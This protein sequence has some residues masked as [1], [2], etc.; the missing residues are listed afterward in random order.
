MITTFGNGENTKSILVKYL[1]FNA[2][3]TYN[4]IIGWPFFNAL[5][6]T[7]SIK[8]DQVK[9]NSVNIDPGKIQ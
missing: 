3:S 8:D 6:A 2:A 5:E 1:I 4:V 7:L 9:V